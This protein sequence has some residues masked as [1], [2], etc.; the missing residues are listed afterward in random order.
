MSMRPGS[1]TDQP[2]AQTAAEQTAPLRLT[3]VEGGLYAGRRHDY[4]KAAAWLFA[5]LFGP[6][7]IALAVLIVS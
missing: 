6:A 5:L 4:L 2:L 3:L 1:I 7:L